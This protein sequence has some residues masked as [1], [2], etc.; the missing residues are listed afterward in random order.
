MDLPER[1]ANFSGACTHEAALVNRLAFFP[2]TRA[3]FVN[4]EVKKLRKVEFQSGEED[5]RDH[6]VFGQRFGVNLEDFNGF[7]QKTSPTSCQF[8]RNR[9]C[10]TS[11][12][13]FG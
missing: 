9:L 7:G 5:H 6:P 12:T 11:G 4:S 1:N 10:S 3:N 13:L 8:G 2:Q